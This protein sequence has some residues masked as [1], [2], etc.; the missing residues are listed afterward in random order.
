M[1]LLEVKRDVGGEA[2]PPVAEGALEPLQLEVDGVDVLLQLALGGELAAAVVAN[3]LLQIAVLLLVDVQ[4]V[5]QNKKLD[6]D[7][8][9]LIISHH[10]KE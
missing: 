6:H 8:L 5:M 9:P 1:D 4:T 3:H 10:S 7:M 2:G